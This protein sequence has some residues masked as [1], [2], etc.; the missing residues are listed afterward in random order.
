MRQNLGTFTV[1]GYALWGVKYQTEVESLDRIS[2]RA[3]FAFR[4]LDKTEELLLNI[5]A[6]GVISEEEQPDMKRVLEKL[7][8]LEGI[9]QNLKIWVKKNL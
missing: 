5:A 2:L 4:E 9:T 3:I 1:Q 6:D 8:E 7:E